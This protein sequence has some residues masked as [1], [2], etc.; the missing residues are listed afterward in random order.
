[1]LAIAFALGS[2]GLWGVCDFAGGILSR[3]YAVVAI[4]VLV[5]GSALVGAAVI[6]ASARPSADLNGVLIGL[7][8][9]ACGS[10]SVTAFYR[11]MSLGL[12]SVASPLLSSGSVLAFAIAVAA[13]ERPSALAITGAGLALAG[14]VLTALEEHGSGGDRRTAVSFSALSAVAFGCALY[15]LGRASHETGSIVAVLSQRTS[16]FL[17]LALLAARFRPSLRIGR[18]GLAA[19]AA[20][21]I[22]TTGALLLFGLAANRGLIS[23]VSILSSLYPIVTV[24][25][26]HAFLGER[27]RGR[28]LAGIPVMLAGIALVAAGR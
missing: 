4:T 19:V 8:A 9:G 26:A 25:L 14:T 16:S 17:V 22:G 21:G 24:L 23:I 12:I 1:V 11:A 18:R 2:S 15:L 5:Q 7:A 20:I 27:L 28:Q 3:R 6:A 10:V 13:G